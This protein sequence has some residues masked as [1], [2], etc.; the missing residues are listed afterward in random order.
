MLRRL[1]HG[2]PAPRARSRAARSGPRCEPGTYQRTARDGIVSSAAGNND[3]VVGCPPRGACPSR[4]A[5][6]GARRPGAAPSA[7]RERM[8]VPLS[9][10]EHDG[11]PAI[12]RCRAVGHRVDDPLPARPRCR[13][14]SSGSGWS[15]LIARSG[16]L[17]NASRRR[18]KLTVV[19]T[20]FYTRPL[21]LSPPSELRPARRFTAANGRAVSTSTTRRRSRE[22]P[23][24]DRR[25]TARGV[26]RVLRG[27][28]G[29]AASPRRRSCRTAT[30]RC[31][32]PPRG[33]CS[34]S[35]TS[36]ASRSRPR[37][38]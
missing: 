23:S 6:S 26:P 21:A 9:R 22:S 16:R 32:S 30:P 35:R 11:D 13:S 37:R 29:T 12:E 8:R 2:R 5:P 38:A 4:G 34:S 14:S 28:A 20:P 25:R 1:R 17:R 18:C 36:W 3:D 24:L 15:V 7:R 10:G 31:C 19:R 27:D 33:W